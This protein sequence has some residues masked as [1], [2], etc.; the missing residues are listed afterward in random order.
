[1]LLKTAHAKAIPRLSPHPMWSSVCGSRWKAIAVRLMV[2]VLGCSC[3]CPELVAQVTPPPTTAPVSTPP[4]LQTPPPARPTPLA[5]GQ[6]PRTAN[7]EMRQYDL[8]RYTNGLNKIDKPERAVVDWVLRETGT[9]VWFTEPFGFLSANRTA[10]SAYHTPDVQNVV[11][12]MVDRFVN[13]PTDAQILKMRLITVSSPN[14]RATALP[15]IQDVN[16]QS[17]GVQAWLLTKE[18]AAVLTNM[19]K[20]RSD[21]REAQNQQ[22]P[23]FNGQSQQIASTK[24]RTYVRTIRQAS[25]VWPPYEPEI[26]EVQEGYQLEISPLLDLDGETI[27]CVIRAQIDQVDKLVPVDIE[28]PLPNGQV[29]HTRIEVPQMVSWRLHE[30]FRWQSDLVLLLSCGVVASP[31]RQPTAIPLLNLDRLIGNTPGRADALL[32]IEFGGR[33][34]EGLAPVQRSASA[35][36]NI[37]RGRY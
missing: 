33:A 26:A 35:S 15:L 20:M 7:Q 31:D 9:D 37:S 13:G 34:A 2:L 1:M 3:C 21:T 22:F 36:G 27:E 19:L 24:G 18:N 8:S 5:S 10:L 14:W 25:T 12:R 28:L 30:R 29:H 23:I 11:K 4:S 17:P 6:L 16:V 32:F